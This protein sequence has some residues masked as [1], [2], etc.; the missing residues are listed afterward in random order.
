MNIRNISYMSHIQARTQELRQGGGKLSREGLHI[1]MY[2][3]VYVLPSEV[4]SSFLRLFL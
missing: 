3:S 4:L 2:L 1:I